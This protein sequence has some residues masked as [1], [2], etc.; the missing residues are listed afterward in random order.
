MSEPLGTGGAIR[1]VLEH[2]RQ[3]R[4][5]VMN[6]DTYTDVDLQDLVARLESPGSDLTV[7]VTHLNDIAR[8]GA[9][10]IAVS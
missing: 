2:G 3:P 5:I 1:L 8:Y 6:G 10:V 4:V 9:I 7:A